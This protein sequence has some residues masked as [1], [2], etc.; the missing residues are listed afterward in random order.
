M[1][2]A[3]G[4]WL[5]SPQRPYALRAFLE[6]PLLVDWPMISQVRSRRRAQPGIIEEPEA[7]IPSREGI[8]IFNALSTHVS[9]ELLLVDISSYALM[10]RTSG[11]TGADNAQISTHVAHMSAALYPRRPVLSLLLGPAFLA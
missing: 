1:R 11:Q 3:G 2:G 6:R 7:T 5:G 8:A 9:L 4:H 10:K